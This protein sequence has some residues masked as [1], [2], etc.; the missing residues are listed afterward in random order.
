MTTD[1][2]RIGFDIL[3]DS[4]CK[5]LLREQFLIGLAVEATQVLELRQVHIEI[6]QIETFHGLHVLLVVEKILLDQTWTIKTD[7]VGHDER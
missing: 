6:L 5:R 7:G 2:K 3:T 1:R 4:L